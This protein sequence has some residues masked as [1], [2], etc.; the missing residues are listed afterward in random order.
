MVDPQPTQPTQ[1]SKIKETATNIIN[2][3]IFSFAKKRI[4]SAIVSKI[5]FLG[6]AIFNPILS[7]VI[8]K[9]LEIFYEELSKIVSFAIIDS[10]V[11]EEAEEYLRAKVELYNVMSKPK[12]EV[13]PD[14]IELAK[15]EFKKRMAALI[16]VRR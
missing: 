8:G 3:L 16:R 4:I 5:P 7:F 15:A 14:E 1:S 6:A 10:Q 12:Y 11:D 9:L 2:E 13:T